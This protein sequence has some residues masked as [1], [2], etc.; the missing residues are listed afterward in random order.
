M[1]ELEEGS[2]LTMRTLILIMLLFACAIASVGCNSPQAGTVDY[3]E[4]QEAEQALDAEQV[5]Q[6]G[7]TAN[8]NE[9]ID[10]ASPAPQTTSTANQDVDE[11]ISPLEGTETPSATLS[12]SD[13]SNAVRVRFKNEMPDTIQIH[14]VGTAPSLENEHTTV[15]FGALTPDTYS[16][17]EVPPG[18]FNGDSWTFLVYVDGE[19]RPKETNCSNC[20]SFGIGEPYKRWTITFYTPDPDV[21]Y[22]LY[23]PGVRVVRD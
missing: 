8:T 15:D 4:T 20:E 16:E 10:S 2:R 21:Q 19:L 18:M 9:L 5:S 1:N 7:P 11:R 14:I 17:Y 22:F 23:P 13:D 3:L 6:S 12:K